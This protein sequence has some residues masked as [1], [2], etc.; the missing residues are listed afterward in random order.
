MRS[1]AARACTIFRSTRPSANPFAGTL[2]QAAQAAERKD[3][4][5]GTVVG[6]AFSGG[7]TRAAAFSYGV[8]KQ[9]ERTPTPHIG[10]HDLLDHVGIVSGVSGGSI[11][12]AYYGLK[13]RA[14]L[15]DFREQFLTQDLMAELNTSVNLLNV[16]RALGGGVN[17]DNRLRD[18]FNAHLYHDATFSA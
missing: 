7:G 14:A 4:T 17:T 9:L 18:W 13:G 6:L 3:D 2:I 5:G 15:A 12:A 11:I 8:L 16:S 1:A 10:G